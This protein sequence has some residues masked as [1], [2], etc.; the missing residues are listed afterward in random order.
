MS[1]SIRKK[2]LIAPNSFKECA[3]SV[4]TAGLIHDAMEKYARAEFQA[5]PELTVV[6]VS[7]GGDGLLEVCRLKFNLR[8]L[9]YKIPN[10]FNGNIFSCPVGYSE[11]NKTIYIESA[12]VLGLKLIP[13]EFRNPLRLSSGG[14]GEL[15]IQIA[16][17]AAKGNLDIKRIVIGIGGTGT[18]DL[19]L[20][21]LS[22]FGLLLTDSEGKKLEVLPGNFEKSEGLLWQTPDFNFEI[23]IIID[24]K[25]PL[26]G[27]NGASIVFGPQKGL[28]PAKASE[29][30]AQFGRLLRMMNINSE[31]ISSLSG[32]GGGLAAA[33]QIFFGGKT[34]FSKDFIKYELGVD[35]ALN[36]YDAVI[37]GEGKVDS[38]SMLDKGAMVVASEYSRAGTPVYF[39]CGINDSVQTLNSNMKF[40]ELWK[41]FTSVKESID[42]FEAGINKACEAIINDLK[43]GSGL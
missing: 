38:Q 19:G 16:G 43:F 41:Y 9:H 39:I 29:I 34:V 31:K 40:I 36:R 25:N 21:M 27:E 32:A 8:I 5:A 28:L 14:M 23:E 35:S 18:N 10:P 12:E 1:D 24:V 13:E 4:R 15:L 30:D 3:G 17:D 26:L 20:G 7:D 2:I 37:T 11:K 6:P 42:N 22:K 33:F